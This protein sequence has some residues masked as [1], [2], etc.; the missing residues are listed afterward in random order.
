MYGTP[1]LPMPKEGI[2]LGSH[3]LVV[4]KMEIDGND[5]K[6]TYEAKV[7]APSMGIPQKKMSFTT[8]WEE[9]VIQ[10]M[11]REV[12]TRKEVVLAMANKDGGSHIDPELTAKYA[13]IT[14]FNSMGLEI[15]ARNMEE[16]KAPDND[17]AA[18]TVRQI[19]HE[20]LLSLQ[21]AFSEMFPSR[22]AIG[23]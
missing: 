21:D 18:A 22:A 8:W 23:M 4:M 7:N 1:S 15:K 17:V 11:N 5:A 19:A 20:V 6:A 2:P 14:R 13:D 10:D 3:P 9:V 16:S 12:L